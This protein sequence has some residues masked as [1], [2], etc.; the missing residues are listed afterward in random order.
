MVVITYPYS[1]AH[2]KFF[3]VTSYSTRV[4]LRPRFA[5]WGSSQY[6]YVVLLVWKIP[7]QI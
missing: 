5:L 6:E 1:A 2:Q 3:K 4:E 7:L